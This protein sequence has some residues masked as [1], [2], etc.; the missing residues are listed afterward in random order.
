MRRWVIILSMIRMDG[1]SLFGLQVLQPG[2]G[3]TPRGGTVRISSDR[4]ISRCV[5]LHLQSAH[6]FPQILYVCQLELIQNVHVREPRAFVDS[7][8]GSS[9]RALQRVV[10]HSNGPADHW[11]FAGTLCD[12]YERV[13][14]WSHGLPA[15]LFFVLG[16]APSSRLP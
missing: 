12:P 6:T 5:S 16:C 8:R 1:L 9:A 7:C 4:G 14:V 10:L 3:R 11:P 13:N 15:I 2:P